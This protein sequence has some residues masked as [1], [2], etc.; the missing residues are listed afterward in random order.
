VE[1][2]LR[3]KHDD[4][5]GR[6]RGSNFV[7]VF[8]VHLLGEWVCVGCWVVIQIWWASRILWRLKLEECV[9]GHQF[10]HCSA[11]LKS[12]FSMK[13]VMV[14]GRLQQHQHQHSNTQ[15]PTNF[16]SQNFPPFGPLRRQHE[17]LNPN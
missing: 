16:C 3:I 2:P 4:C 10:A 11:V 15:A 8:G 7:E 5:R 1:L 6:R 13:G 9:W 14:P 12:L 17:T